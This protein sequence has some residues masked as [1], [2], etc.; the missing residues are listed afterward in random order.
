M[1]E[2]EKIPYYQAYTLEKWYLELAVLALCGYTG[3][4]NNRTSSQRW[5]GQVERV[6]WAI[7]TPIP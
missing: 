5:V 2:V 3:S 6:P 4:Y 1:G 7:K